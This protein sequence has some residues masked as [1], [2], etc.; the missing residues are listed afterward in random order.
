[1]AAWAMRNHSVAEESTDRNFAYH[2]M[3]DEQLKGG[4]QTLRNWVLPEQPSHIYP[5]SVS[6]VTAGILLLALLVA[7]PLLMWRFR[8]TRSDAG[9]EAPADGLSRLPQLLWV[10]ALLYLGTVLLSQ[11]F[12]DA[13]IPLDDRMLSPLYAAGLLLLIC[14]AHLWTRRKRTPA[15]LAIAG[16]AI[17]FFAI[18]V[19]HDSYQLRRWHHYGL[20]LMRRAWVQSE[21]LAALAELN[22]P[23]NAVI[24]SNAAD[25]VEFRAG[26]LAFLL[27]S[28]SDEGMRRSNPRYKK[29]LAEMGRRLR[30][31]GGVIV[32]FAENLT[33]RTYLPSAD[34]LK[35][36]LPLQL[37]IATKDGAIYKVA[38]A[39]ASQPT[40]LPTSQP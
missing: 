27:P 37:V 3:T 20:G 39:P 15:L 35:A 6:A 26:G 12:F 25:A 21:T 29:N 10:F 16:I 8:K 40:S 4:L 33:N 9:P 34:E 31:S 11:T 30:R 14:L 28:K 24:Y 7:P 23:A 32:L 5:L 2:W 19:F 36:V 22:L 13:G 17:A 1:M 18:N 38:N